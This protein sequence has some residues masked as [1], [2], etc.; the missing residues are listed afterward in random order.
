[1]IRRDTTQEERRFARNYQIGDTVQPERDYERQGLKKGELYTVID[2]GPS[3]HLTVRAPDGAETKFSPRSVPNLSV[4]RTERGELAVG[5]LVRVTRNE[6]S[7][8]LAN[9]ERFRVTAQS[10]DD[11]TVSDGRR[12]V[13]LPTKTAL[14]LD[15]AY[16]TTV[17][18][19]QGLTENRVLVDAPTNTRTTARDTFYVAISRA[20]Y[21]VHIYTNNADKLP[22]AISRDNE[23]TAALD[24]RREERTKPVLQRPAREPVLAPTGS[25]G[26]A[27]PAARRPRVEA[28][29]DR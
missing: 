10:K 5:D 19:S 8:D 14:H 9:G 3:N 22:R 11:I 16:A 1:M 23:K 29:R 12:S 7:K 18:S 20:R 15:H 25:D 24:L 26:R 4:Y 6:A 13:V 17:H 27:T 28:E 21:E 2:N